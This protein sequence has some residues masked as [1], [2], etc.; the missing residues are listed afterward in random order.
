MN[1]KVEQNK[2]DDNIINN[3]TMGIQS[4]G[5][6]IPT[7]EFSEEEIHN[8]AREIREMYIRDVKHDKGT[9]ADWI[10]WNGFL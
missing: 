10:K 8:Q 9:L 3:S 1:I 7:I 2:I 5:K 6:T 4:R